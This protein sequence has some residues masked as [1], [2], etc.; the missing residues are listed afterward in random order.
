MPY[1]FTFRNM[2]IINSLQFIQ[3]N[4]CM[5][6]FAFMQILSCIFAV[7]QFLDLTHAAC[8]PNDPEG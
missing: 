6:F 5:L 1:N 8:D 4:I 2:L 7:L 3:S